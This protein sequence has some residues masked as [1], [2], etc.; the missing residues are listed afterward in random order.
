MESYQ[1]AE[2]IWK[3]AMSAEHA[4]IPM[5]PYSLVQPARA[6]IMLRKVTELNKPGF[7]EQLAAFLRFH[8]RVYHLGLSLLLICTGFLYISQ[9]DYTMGDQAGLGQ[10]KEALS[11]TNTTIS[12]NST[13]M[14]TSIPTLVI[15]N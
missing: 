9:P 11:I 12:V 2:N 5:P 14:L 15:R 10:Y 8:V 1:D 13:T 3:D 4:D 7:F 6:K